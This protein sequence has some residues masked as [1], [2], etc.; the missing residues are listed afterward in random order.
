M[1]TSIVPGV[2]GSAFTGAVQ[3]T[4]KASDASSKAL[5]K[6]E[7]SKRDSLLNFLNKLCDE[8]NLPGNE[9]IPIM[10]LMPDAL[11]GM[12]G[13]THNGVATSALHL[14]L[15]PVTIASHLSQLPMDTLASADGLVHSIKEYGLFSR[16]QQ[17][18]TLN[19]DQE[20][21]NKRS[22]FSANCRALWN[23][24]SNIS[25]QL[26]EV[27]GK[28]QDNQGKSG[29]SHARVAESSAYAAASGF[30]GTAGLGSLAVDGIGSLF[31]EISGLVEFSRRE[32]FV[33][34]ENNIYQAF[35]ACCDS[36]S[37]G[38]SNDTLHALRRLEQAILNFREAEK[39]SEDHSL[40]GPSSSV[41]LRMI[42]SE[43]FVKSLLAVNYSALAMTAA[44][45]VMSD[46]QAQCSQ[47]MQ[48]SAIK[49]SF[50]KDF[51]GGDALNH[52]ANV[53]VFCEQFDNAIGQIDNQLKEIEHNKPIAFSA[54]STVRSNSALV[55]A[56]SLVTGFFG[57]ISREFS[58]SIDFSMND[59]GTQHEINNVMQTRWEMT[60]ADLDA[61]MSRVCALHERLERCNELGFSAPVALGI[62]EAIT[63]G[64]LTAALNV[65][66]GMY[67]ALR[68]LHTLSQSP[69]IPLQLDD[70]ERQRAAASA[71]SVIGFNRETANTM[72]TAPVSHNLS[73]HQHIESVMQKV[74][75]THRSYR[76]FM[77]PG[78]ERNDIDSAG[79]STIAFSQ[80]NST[81]FLFGS[82]GVLALVALQ[83]GIGTE[84]LFGAF[85]FS[86]EAKRLSDGVDRIDSENGSKTNFSFACNAT[87]LTEHSMPDSSLTQTASRATYLISES[88]MSRSLIV[89]LC[90]SGALKEMLRRLIQEADDRIKH[91]PG[92]LDSAVTSDDLL[93]RLHG[94]ILQVLDEAEIN[95]NPIP[96]LNQD[97]ASGLDKMSKASIASAL[98]AHGLSIAPILQSI[99]VA[100]KASVINEQIQNEAVSH[101]SE[102]SRIISTSLNMIQ[103]FTN[104]FIVETKNLDAPFK[105]ST[106]AES[107]DAASS[108]SMVVACAISLLCEELFELC[109]S[110]SLTLLDRE[111]VAQTSEQSSD[112]SQRH[113]AASREAVA[114]DSGSGQEYSVT[115]IISALRLTLSH[116]GV[117]LAHFASDMR[118]SDVLQDNL[119]IHTSQR[120]FIENMVVSL[121]KCSAAFLS[122]AGALSSMPVSSV[123]S[124]DALR[125]LIHS[126]DHTLVLRPVHS[127]ENST[128]E[129]H[130][131][132]SLLTATAT[133]C[134]SSILSTATKLLLQASILGL[135]TTLSIAKILEILCLHPRPEQ[136]LSLE[137]QALSQPNG[138]S[139]NTNQL[140]QSMLVAGSL[141][142][143]G[144]SDATN[145]GSSNSTEQSMRGIQ[146]AIDNRIDQV[147]LLEDEEEGNALGLLSFYEHLIRIMAEDPARL[148]AS[149][150]NDEYKKN[151]EYKNLALRFNRG[152]I[153]LSD[154]HSEHKGLNNKRGHVSSGK[155][156]NPL[157]RDGHFQGCNDAADLLSTFIEKA[158]HSYATDSCYLSKLK[159]ALKGSKLSGKSVQCWEFIVNGV[160]DRIELVYRRQSIF[161][162]KSNMAG[163]AAL[164]ER[165]HDLLHN[166]TISVSDHY[167]SIPE[168]EPV[169][170]G[171]SNA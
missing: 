100:K 87:R 118:A 51:S 66:A 36:F 84:A 127:S 57:M 28:H 154:Y 81:G 73:L 47:N 75:L 110:R 164:N 93:P 97:M 67:S 166:W 49:A 89:S 156:G 90:H 41:F 163:R 155:K 171:T 105:N 20:L 52:S 33:P 150:T 114:A 32:T 117:S 9:K 76:N 24:L 165:K 108:A 126:M 43:P 94:A 29:K 134:V 19:A 54:A 14:S 103:A 160:I 116:L 69:S 139:L 58:G 39:M 162:S 3:G 50:I 128:M 144:F 37:S 64:S 48:E 120:S 5:D 8:M 99:V 147:A 101:D 158:V 44:H 135:D 56:A 115:H 22:E 133:D 122:I 111:K 86:L 119:E 149:G 79:K 6:T 82:L 136:A 130:S 61:L 92:F 112:L 109:I 62:T 4:R 7:L 25:M 30:L 124:V 46:G 143:I 72:G 98:T 113:S 34:G 170:A 151:D 1:T 138:A 123:G 167:E 88:V 121:G 40:T 11:Q 146:A 42:L 78:M 104:N 95:R 18:S 102:L 153:A 142:S 85:R 38:N 26:R 27:I 168:P 140:L 145:T 21:A 141:G 137:W 65:V 60:G 74:V 91:A 131:G 157:I 63:F 15:A 12:L 132:S 80:G 55:I 169:V 31:R 53:T 77:M 59:V 148:R 35:S 70:A 13:F 159:Q 23:E 83:S 71:E 129:S 2:I 161:N 107:T 106:L 10:D 152:G 16:T 125:E 96:G 45:R 17:A 68:E